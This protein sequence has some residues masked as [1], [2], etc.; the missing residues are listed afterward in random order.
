[1]LG[2]WIEGNPIIILT[3][4]ALLTVAS[5]HYAQ[6]IA[7]DS[8]TETFVDDSSLLYVTYEH[9]YVD[10]FGTESIVVLVEGDSVTKPESLEAMAR[11][12]AHMEGI[13]NVLG[14]SCIV[15][16]I[17]DLEAKDT[18]VRKV[19]NSQERID[20][21]LDKLEH[22]NPEM[23]HAILPDR[24]HTMIAID[25]PIYIEDVTLEEVLLEVIS[26]VNMAEFPSGA[27]TIVTGD[28]GL[29][30]AIN[31]EM[32]R[33]MGMLLVIAI[34]LMVVALFLVFRHVHLKLLPLP[35]V[36]LGIV[37][38]F[39]MMGFL[40]IHMTMVSMSAFPI[41]IGLG[42]DYAIQFQ[43]R[44]E[45]EFQRGESI[46]S[47]AIDTVTHTAPAVLIAL[48]LT[49]AGFVSLFSSTV[50]MIQDFGLLCLIGI[51]MCYLSSLFVGVTVL[52]QMGK[53]RFTNGTTKERTKS[54]TG[55]MIGKL[56]IFLIHRWQVVLVCAFVLSGAGLYADSKVPIQTDFKEFI[57]QDLPP[58]IQFRHLETIFGGTDELNLIIQGDVT[59]PKTLEWMDEFG[60]YI[61]DSREQVYGAT[62]LATI[63]KSY[64]DEIIPDDKSDVEAV[65][66]KVPYAIKYP[67]MDGHDTTQ[68]RLDIGKAFT[69]LG[70][71]G[72]KRLQ[73][74]IDKDIIWFEAPP[75]I[76][77]I[78]TGEMTV[79][80]TVISAL[81]TGRVQMTF[82]GLVLIFFILLLIYRDLI[83]AVLP[84]LPMLVVI[85]WMGGV[86]Y[87]S[88]MEY[89]PLTATLGALILGVGSEYAVLTMERFYEEKEKTEDTME[90]LTIAMSSIG[91]AIIASGLTTVFGFS[92]LIASPFM[93]TSNF[94]TVTV[95]S[96]IFALFATFTVFPVLLIRLEYWRGRR[97]ALNADVLNLLRMIFRRTN[98]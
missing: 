8:S 72:I 38:T 86:M 14:T 45:E 65:L 77:V 75:G 98:S 70:Q 73:E 44:I 23:V 20:E 80:N 71:V 60:T 19:P 36:L 62:S 57:P 3:L 29:R 48:V 95:L 16:A 28:A 7:M 30:S 76:S 37:W 93:I 58:L 66:D 18:G 83:K 84:I 6:N 47:A 94:G 41:L 43:N 91:V 54:Q 25:V 81:T 34:L 46:A 33:S 9:L 69:N 31:L 89:T 64:N 68:I 59:D 82:L 87:L 13:N 24:K 56:A 11:L 50:P 63:V 92:A 35:I 10:R 51:I 55:S 85:G 1:M 61:A 2:T 96:V 88:G 22:T 4:A 32:S 5:I 27:D 53:G 90:A 21:I 12:T 67:Y 52:Y 15:E 42:I 39:G 40:N 78:Q 79:M 49:S 17:M 97:A 74:E 26:A